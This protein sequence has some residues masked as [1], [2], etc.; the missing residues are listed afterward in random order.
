MLVTSLSMLSQ[1]RTA[2]QEGKV[3]LASGSMLPSSYVTKKKNEQKSP[4]TN[5]K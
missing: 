1:P 3:S 4:K 5:C 2:C